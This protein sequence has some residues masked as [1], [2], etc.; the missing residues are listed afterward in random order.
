MKP[1]V[2]WPKLVVY[3]LEELF[4][5]QKDLAELCG[6]TQQ[7]VSNWKITQR[8]P[9]ARP[10]RKLVELL[11]KNGVRI[12]LFYEDECSEDRPDPDMA[13]LEGIYMS[14]PYRSRETLLEFARFTARKES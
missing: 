1:K 8:P 3:V 10:K 6:V 7:C 5:S 11:R 12:S 9:G 13:E 14:L 2:N 4:M